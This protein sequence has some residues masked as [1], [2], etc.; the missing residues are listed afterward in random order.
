VKTF[1]ERQRQLRVSF[2]LLAFK[3]PDLCVGALIG[4]SMGAFIRD[5]IRHAKSGIGFFLSLPR[6]ERQ[7]KL[8]AFLLPAPFSPMADTSVTL[9]KGQSQPKRSAQSAKPLVQPQ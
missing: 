5:T 4:A 2:I 1:T 6:R 3:E 8:G 9:R 7:Q